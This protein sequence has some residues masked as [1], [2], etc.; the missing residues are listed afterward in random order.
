MVSDQE[1][2]KGTCPRNMFLLIP[3]LFMED[4]LIEGSE[5]LVVPR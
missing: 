5:S 1:Y 3:F 2:P 4:M